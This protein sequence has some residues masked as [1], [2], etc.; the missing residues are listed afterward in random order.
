MTVAQLKKL[1]DNALDFG[2]VYL[3]Q[4][5]HLAMM[6]HLVRREGM[7][8]LTLD[9]KLSKDD[10]A[11]QLRR[12]IAQSGDVEAVILV[13]DTW[14]ADAEPSSFELMER[15]KLSIPQ[16]DAMGLCRMRESVLVTLESPVYSCSLRQQ[17]RRRDG[18]I[19]LT[20]EAEKQEG[21]SCWLE[22]RFFG[23][24]PAAERTQ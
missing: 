4:T 16:A 18:A 12:H 5:G 11:A 8:V 21:Q 9:G 23:F 10:A 2:V 14:Y 6:V 22:G 13:S 15:L 20:G 24:F 19:E 3:Q 17:Y 7:D 1:A